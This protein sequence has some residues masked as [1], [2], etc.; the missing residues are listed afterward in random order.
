M[1]PVI[2]TKLS[3][4]DGSVHGNCFRACLASIMEIDIDSIPAFE[5]M[6][7]EWHIPFMNF[8]FR[9]G[10]EFDGTGRFG[11]DFHDENFLKYPGVD[12]YI[13]VGGTSPREWVTRGHAVIY[14]NGEL[15][16][17][18]YPGGGG[19]VEKQNFYMIKRREDGF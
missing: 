15:V 2:Q 10:Y 4:Q 5:D 6:G 11:D 7:N 14:K 3:S 19:V 18:P 1:K 12:G 9:N 17:D 16:H 8:L 13:I